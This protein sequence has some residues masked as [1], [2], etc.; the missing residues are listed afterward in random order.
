MQLFQLIHSHY[1]HWFRIYL[2]FISS[3]SYLSSLSFSLFLYMS[4]NF[5]LFFFLVYNY[6]NIDQSRDQKCEYENKHK[7]FNNHIILKKYLSFSCH[8]FFFFFIAVDN[9]KR[10]YED[11]LFKVTNSL[12]MFLQD[13]KYLF[14]QRNKDWWKSCQAEWIKTWMKSNVSIV[15][16]HKVLGYFQKFELKSRTL[17][18]WGK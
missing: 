5:F 4:I 15:L 16:S 2:P 7:F 17:R 6:L 13:K 12:R 9:V 11:I 14:R 10:I 3:Y 1:F 8:F 18:R